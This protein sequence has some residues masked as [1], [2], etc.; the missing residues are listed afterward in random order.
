MSEL[1]LQICCAPDATV[2]FERLKKDWLITGYFFNPNIEPTSEYIFREQDAKDLAGIYGVR[3]VEGE[4]DKAGWL[5]AIKGL[6]LLPEGSA[7]CQK[8][9]AYRLEQSANYA[10]QHSFKAFG[11][12]LTTSPHKD[13]NFIHQTGF[14]LS[15]QYGIDYLDV[16]L[17]KNNG[18]KRSLELC[19]ELSLYRQ[20]YCGCRW[21]L[22]G[23]RAHLR[24]QYL[25]SHKIKAS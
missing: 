2:A 8:C 17:R 22:P 15:E 16:N 4:S 10:A 7:R 23:I 21:S 5:L 25:N 13:L 3:Y 14:R 12:T 9:I 20:D 24:T 18:F 19:R 11:T 1:L 6:E